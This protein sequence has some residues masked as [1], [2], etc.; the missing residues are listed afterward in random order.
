MYYGYPGYPYY[1]GYGNNDGC[2]WIWI[3][4]VVAII[5]FI[6]CGNNSRNNYIRN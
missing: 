6:F 5:F 2:N 4:I 3:I 1:P